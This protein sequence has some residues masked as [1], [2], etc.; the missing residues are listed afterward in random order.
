MLI[1]RCSPN[2]YRWNSHF[3]VLMRAMILVVSTVVINAVLN[4]A[5]TMRVATT[6]GR[7]SI[8]RIENRCVDRREIAAG[9]RVNIAHNKA[10]R[11][12]DCV[13]DL[14]LGV[15]KLQNESF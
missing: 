15:G 2:S 4:I 11:R 6:E 5:F 3:N 7:Y 10:S 1:G 9:T 13:F 14:Y 12:S 8:K